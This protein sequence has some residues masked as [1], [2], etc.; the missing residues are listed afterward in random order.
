[1]YKY[2]SVYV[3]IPQSVSLFIYL[4]CALDF[5]LSSPRHPSPSLHRAPH[6]I[7]INTQILVIPWPDCPPLLSGITYRSLS[8]CTPTNT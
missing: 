8:P 5:S 3:P 2:I 7:E 6:Q 1:M 4:S